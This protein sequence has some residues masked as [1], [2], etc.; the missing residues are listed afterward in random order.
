ML[1]VSS[2]DILP[3]PAQTEERLRSV[4]DRLHVR[5]LMADTL[6]LGAQTW[7][8]QNVQ[9]PYWRFY[10]NGQ[11]GAYITLA[12]G[13]R[14]S[15]EAGR[16][17]FVPAGVRFGCGNTEAIDHFYLHFDVVGV[18]HLL[19][20]AVFDSP[21]ALPDDSDFNAR[22]AGFAQMVE[23]SPT[24]SLTGQC[25]AKALIYE[26]LARS[27]EQATEVQRAAYLQRAENL[28]PIAPALE[29]IEDHLARDLTVSL[30]AGLCCFSPDYF[31]RKFKACTRQTPTD[32]IR[33]CRADKAALALL[34]TGDSLEQIAE[35]CGFGNR[36]YF[37]RVFGQIVGVSP[38][39]YR[40]TR[41]V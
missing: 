39:A 37:T 16:A 4:I 33:Q 21:V 25:R 32:Y 12:N 41:R 13:N 6:W 28:E 2:S 23:Q 15:F 31:A 34:F 1:F 38:A 22:V 36:Y 24:L 14:F 40:K 35:S 30:L 5:V 19:M 9:S 17:Y 7:N 18:P 27:L 11:S 3:K 10:Q 26:G 29:H 20:Q 8:A